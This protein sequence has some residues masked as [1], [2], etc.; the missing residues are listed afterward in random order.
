MQN[1]KK[2]I[3]RDLTAWLIMVPTLL[4]FIFY[5]FSP[6]INNISLSFYEV[7]GGEKEKF[8]WFQNY[9]HLFKSDLFFKAL[10]NTFE[11]AFWSVIIGFLVPV[12]LAVILNEVIHLKG[13]FRTVIYLP[14]VIPGIAV[15]VMWAYLFSPN[16]Y[17]ALNSLFNIE[18][19][20]LD[21]KK[22]VIPLIVLTMTWKGAG[23]TTLIYLATLQSID[24]VQYEA[25]RLE[26]A[27]AFARFRYVTW[28]HL[29]SQMKVLFI[30]Q[31][32]T[33]FQ[34]FYEPMVM[35][36]G[37]GPA[38]ESISLVYLIYNYAFTE[39]DVGSA[40]ALSVVVSLILFMMAGLYFWILREKK[41]KIKKVKKVKKVVISND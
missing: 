32:V 40:A 8:I 9:E 1:I 6:L 38:N 31:I 33:V 5:I 37:G 15:A 10:T 41:P 23:A 16:S 2:F 11:Y 34:L 30:L 25:A 26:G 35:T 3:R 14:N 18:S 7:V 22:L 13:F 20:W 36:K 28:P 29:L 27:G 24:T 17:G 21:D 19:L 39:G 12:I 4:L